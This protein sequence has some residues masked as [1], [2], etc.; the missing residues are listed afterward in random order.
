MV[1]LSRSTMNQTSL[2]YDWQGFRCAYRVSHPT[3]SDDSRAFVLVHPIGVGLSGKFWQRFRQIGL[4][5]GLNHPIYTPDLLGCGDSAMPSL[6]YYPEDWAEQLRYFIA[7]VVQKPVILVVQ[8]ALLPVAIKLNQ[9]SPDS[10]DFLILSG[11]PSWQLITTATNK[12]KQKWLWNLFFDSPVGIGNLFYRYARRREFLR[13]FSVRRLFAEEQDVDAQWLDTLE[14]GATD[15]QSRYAV[16]SFLAGF[17]RENYETAIKQI[18]QPT[19]VL[20]GNEASSIGK[21]GKTA[22]PQQRL[23]A[24]LKFLPNGR[25]QLI[26]GRNVLPYESPKAFVKAVE[27]FVSR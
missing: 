2:F 25:G 8:G 19:L 7:E 11:P 14:S 18:K 20:F 6:A 22:S 4:E 9:I 17:W 5:K 13:S 26:S 15:L 21:E 16:F 3:P 27:E 1:S 12:T 23:D 10:F 24:Y